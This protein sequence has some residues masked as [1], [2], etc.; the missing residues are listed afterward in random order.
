VVEGGVILDFELAPMIEASGAY[1]EISS[2]GTGLRVFMP[3]QWG[4]ESLYGGEKNDVGVF[5]S[6]KGAACA[7]TF[8]TLKDGADRDQSLFDL[9]IERRGGGEKKKTTDSGEVEEQVLDHG[10]L[11]VETFRE[12]VAHVK[13]DDRF[14]AFDEWLPMVRAAKE[15]YEVVDPDRLGEVFEIVEAWCETWDGGHDPDKLNEVWEREA[16][17]GEKAGL[18]SWLHYAHEAGWQWPA[19]GRAEPWHQFPTP[20]AEVET[21]EDFTDRFVIIG[22]K[23]YDRLKR[24]YISSVDE[25]GT[26]IA[27]VPFPKPKDAKSLTAAMR[28][29]QARKKAQRFTS[30]SFMPGEPE[31]VLGVMTDA[32]GHMIEVED[33]RL[34]NTWQPPSIPTGEQ[35]FPKTW[36]DHVR[37]LYP[38]EA[39]HMFDWLALKVQTNKIGFALVL[40]GTPG[41]GKDL[42]LRPIVRALSPHAAGSVDIRQMDGEF[43]GDVIANKTLVVVQEANSGQGAKDLRL[44]EGMFRTLIAIGEPFVVNRKGKPQM[45]I[46]N[47]ADY[48]FTMN[49]IGG[50]HIPVDDRRYCV[51]Y[52]EA[53]AMTEA[54]YEAYRRDYEGDAAV[55]AWLARRQCTLK[56]GQRAPMTTAKKAAQASSLSRPAKAIAEKIKVRVK[57][58]AWV[59]VDSLSS[60][61]GVEF[62]EAGGDP[63]STHTEIGKILASIGWTRTHHWARG[64]VEIGG[65]K[66]VVWQ[67]AFP[68]TP[69]WSKD[70][71]RDALKRG[72]VSGRILKEVRPHLDHIQTRPG[73]GR[74][75]DQQ[76]I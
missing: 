69:V 17:A 55:V 8:D 32:A 59:T 36:I 29:D 9:V 38:E 72:E 25:L 44:R 67:P 61:F 40:G 28:H 19:A 26:L 35:P 37:R 10:R 50:L 56:P 71:I 12:I 15:Y 47:V 34:F 63:T 30:A 11:E 27:L 75:N 39:D 43:Y 64:R 58:L 16:R 23:F 6:A 74:K 51:A 46:P 33:A 22:G 31:Q 45:P 73:Y 1:V 24:D 4:D 48:V 13:N 2:S 42:L 65:E 5:V 57:H 3:R 18:G 60:E 14:D 52:T 7:L 49:E 76:I 68:T 41:A 70:E 21:V 66:I 20:P 54:D 62:S 53:D